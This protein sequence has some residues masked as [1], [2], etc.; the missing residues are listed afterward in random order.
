MA[1]SLKN[2]MISIFSII[3]SWFSRIFYDELTKMGTKRQQH[4]QF[5][6]GHLTNFSHAFSSRKI[7]YAMGI[8]GENQ[9]ATM[10][11]FYSFF[12]IVKL[13]LQSGMK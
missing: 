12:N 8:L 13:Q 11:A 7:L 5:T 2:K 6:D 10:I 1:T 3:S 9:N 4:G